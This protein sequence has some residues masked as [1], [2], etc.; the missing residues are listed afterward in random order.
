M[1]LSPLSCIPSVSPYHLHNGQPHQSC[2]RF[3]WS[4][5]GYHGSSAGGT[6]F[7]PHWRLLPFL[8]LSEVLLYIFLL[9][10]VP[11]SDASDWFCTSR[12][13]IYWTSENKEKQH[14]LHLMEDYGILP[15][16]EDIHKYN[17]HAASAWFRNI[18][19]LHFSNEKCADCL[20]VSSLPEQ[21]R[22]QP[23]S[24]PTNSH[25]CWQQWFPRLQQ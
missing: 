25:H 2:R 4:E 20:Y 6:L 18:W 22:C 15:Y 14:L 1:P 17:N 13:R 7:L 9:F 21:L 10:P 8:L 11:V 24:A 23:Y 12:T 5:Y 3:H 19:F 16:P